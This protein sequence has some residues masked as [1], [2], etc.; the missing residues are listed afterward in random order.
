MITA[1]ILIMLVLLLV[2]RFLIPKMLDAR[3]AG[4]KYGTGLGIFGIYTVVS[5]IMF[6]YFCSFDGKEIAQLTGSEVWNR[7]ICSF[8][9]VNLAMVMV[10]AIYYLARDKRKLSQ[11][12]KIKLKDL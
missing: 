6:R 10:S 1:E 5:L 4:A 8:L 2:A 11:E 7:V 3:S 12:E 9:L